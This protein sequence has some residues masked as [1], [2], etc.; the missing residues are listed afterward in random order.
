MRKRRQGL[1]SPFVVYRQTHTVHLEAN[2]IARDQR[3]PAQEGVGGCLRVSAAHV[4]L[5]PITGGSIRLLPSFARF[6]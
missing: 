6:S 5:C 4:S 3:L 1:A 2:A